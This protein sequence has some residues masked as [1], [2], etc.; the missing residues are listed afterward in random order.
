M[1][2]NLVIILM[3]RLLFLVQMLGHL[4]LDDDDCC[5]EAEYIPRRGKL[6]TKPTKPTKEKTYILST[7]TEDIENAK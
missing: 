6:V 5:D 1:V 7:L 3:L 2:Q 4:R